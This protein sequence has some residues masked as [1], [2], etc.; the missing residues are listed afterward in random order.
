MKK[1]NELMNGLRFGFPD[2]D[3]DLNGWEFLGALVLG[4][5]ICV[6]PFLIKWILVAV[7]FGG[8]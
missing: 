6:L 2:V 4:V 3:A 1:V 7:H 5:G 8:V